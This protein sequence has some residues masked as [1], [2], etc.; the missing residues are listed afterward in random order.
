METKLL[1]KDFFSS[2]IVFLISLPL[3]IGIAIACGLPIHTGI[4]SAIVGGVLVGWLSGNS[5]QVSGPAAGLI[6]VVVEILNSMGLHKLSLVVFLAGIFQIFFGIFS[7][8]NWFRAISPAIIE[9]MLSGIGLTIFIT[10][11]HIMLDSK[12][13]S[14]FVENVQNLFGII[15]DTIFPLKDS[16]H[17]VAGGIGLLTIFIIVTW[18]FIPI[19]KL[20]I[21]PSALIAVIISSLVFLIFDLQIN[22]LVMSDNFWTNIRFIDFD[23]FKYAFEPKVIS[24]AL[25]LTFVASAETLFTSAAIDKLCPRS[26]TDYNKEILAQGIGNTLAGSLGVLPVTGVI[27]RS[28]ANINAGAQTRVSTMLHGFWILIFVS[29]LPFIF[30][31]IPTASLAAILVYTGIKLVKIQE[32]K[33]LFKISKAEFAVYMIT[34][35]GVIFLNLFNGII[36]GLIF[37]LLISIYKALKLNIFIEEYPSEHKTIIKLSGSITFIQLP[38]LIEIFETLEDKNNVEICPQKLH[39]ID[40]A[41]ADFITEWEKRRTIKGKETKIDWETIQKTYP[42]F[43]WAEFENK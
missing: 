6:L 30:N 21:I 14:T 37:A 33:Y 9:G 23:V 7:L 36:L 15:Y 11:F 24:Y 27:V 22:H 25:I 29:F 34:F 8:G 38:Q 13:A 4:I 41:C 2:I 43:H 1:K 16:M 3:C 40:H 17:H 18:P 35:L 31:Y 32:A 19:K 20:R 42:E 28:I 39:F 26:K 5:L 12:P 10:Q